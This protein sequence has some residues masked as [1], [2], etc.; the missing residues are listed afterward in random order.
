MFIGSLGENS[1]SVGKMAALKELSHSLGIK[2]L[3]VLRVYCDL[4]TAAFKMT[5]Q[6]ICGHSR[7][8]G[9]VLRA[10]PDAPLLIS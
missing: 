6:L 4:E 3:K 8:P 5:Q 7:T 2:I 1:L 10:L 9:T